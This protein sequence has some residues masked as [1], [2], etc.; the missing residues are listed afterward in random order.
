MLRVVLR[1]VRIELGIVVFLGPIL[2]FDL[3]VV[4]LRTQIFLR[5]R[6]LGCLSQLYAL[7][8]LGILADAVEVR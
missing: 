4:E 5:V 2:S 6:I 3:H 7:P 8:L 1:V